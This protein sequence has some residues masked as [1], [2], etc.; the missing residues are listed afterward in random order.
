MILRQIT[1]PGLAHN[2]YFLGSQGTA[3]V[4]DPRRDC[5]VFLELARAHDMRI[6]HIFETHRNEDYVIGSLELA[7]RCG[8]GI[9]HGHA[10][11]FAYGTPVRDGDEFM[12]GSLLCRV[13]ETPGHTMEHIAVA[14][15]DTAVSDTPCLVFTGDALF[16]G[17]VG[18]TDFFGQENRA[19]VSGMLFNSIHEKI[20]PLGDGVIVCPAHGAGSVCGTE[21]AD[22]ELSTI[23][24]EKATNAL[25]TMKREEFVEYKVAEHHYL[26]PYFRQMEQQNQFGSPVRGHIP[27]LMPM[28]LGQVKNLMAN[29]V[30]LLDIRS[31]T[32]FAAGHIPGSISIWREGISAYAG[33]F[34]DYNTPVVLVDDFN[35]DLEKIAASLFRMGYDN[36][37]GYLAGGFPEWFKAGERTGQF[38][39]WTV[40]ELSAALEEKKDLFLLDVR[41]IENRKQVGYVPGSSHIYVGDLPDRACEVPGGRLVVVYCDAGYKGSLGASILRRLGYSAVVNILGGM[42]AWIKAGYQAAGKNIG[43]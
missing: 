6:T 42:G 43:K 40:Q 5:E 22:H 20:L 8:A 26:P 30:Q 13:L 16:A 21:I 38:E 37:E 28:E 36:L 3:T 31:P 19:R 18:R 25:L 39:A 7:A 14:V 2:S 24:Y 12:V 23:G 34:L 33:Y 35:L 9:F 32:S 4:I 10:T 27:D 17:D 1:S 41:D 29:G 11:D 15:T